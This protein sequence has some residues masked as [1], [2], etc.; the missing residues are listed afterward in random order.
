MA[1]CGECSAE[2]AATHQPDFCGHCG[3]IGGP[4]VLGQLTVSVDGCLRAGLRYRLAGAWTAEA[5]AQAVVDLGEALE[6]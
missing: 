4:W 2:M 5:R 3:T 1:Q 6:A